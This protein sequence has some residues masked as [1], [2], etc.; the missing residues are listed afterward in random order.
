MT[1]HCQAK[2]ANHWF[3]AAAFLGSFMSSMMWRQHVDND[4]K[5]PEAATLIACMLVIS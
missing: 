1:Y 5:Q 2:D 4:V 3:A